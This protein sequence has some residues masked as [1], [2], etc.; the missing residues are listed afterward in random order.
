MEETKFVERMLYLMQSF[1]LNRDVESN[2]HKFI[3]QGN[4][5]DEK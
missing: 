1:K 5:R 2:I 4:I 3:L